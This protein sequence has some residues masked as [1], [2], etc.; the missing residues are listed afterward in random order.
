VLA[1]SL[2]IIGGMASQNV[3]NLVDTAM[4]GS[5]GDNA[6]AGVGLAGFTT[7]M[8]VAFLMGMAS[9]V[10]AMAARAVGA[11]DTERSALALNGGLVLAAII[12]FPLA[13]CLWMTVQ[14]WFAW[15]APD[16]AVAATG[17]SYMAIR[18][19]SVP[20]VGLNFAFR[21]YWNAVDLSRLYMRTLVIMH[22]LNI[23]LSWTLIFG[24][25]GAPALGVRGAAIGTV[26]ATWFGT[27]M[28]VWLG[29]RHA[30]EAGFLAG[31]PSRERMFAMIRISMPAGLQ[32]FLF[33]AG[34][35]VFFWILG[36]I[37]TAELAAGS[38]VLNL[39]LV[40]I[41]PAI[42]F[43]L[44][45]AT[46]V[47]QSLG[48]GDPKEAAAWGWRVSR[49]ATVV[50]GVIV[51]PQLLYPDA[52]LGLFIHSADTIEIARWPLRLA[53]AG[54]AIDA[55]GS[56][57]MNAHLGAG[58]ARRVMLVSVAGQWGFFL[59]LAYLLGPVLGYGL[60]AI[61]ILYSLYRLLLV[62]AFSLSWRGGSWSNVG[63]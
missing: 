27:C 5:L 20:A 24:A 63:L 61:W 50:V 26:A 25:F 48:A 35:T 42:G 31:L 54:A 33:A 41:L 46:L 62:A 30:R 56:V 15:L 53:A 45:A 43:G 18:L 14:T 32:Q 11:G 1:L 23:A 37:G 49:L 51:L 59:P 60:L 13:F 34:M 47:G 4:V 19:L 7:F 36:Q 8:A 12:G 58:S 6:L 39:M 29:L 16:A 2:P 22:A 21:G 38:V 40:A 28:Y 10:Q 3:L 52:V 57:L 9:G 44:A 17:T 55:T